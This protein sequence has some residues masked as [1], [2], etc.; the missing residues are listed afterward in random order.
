M[1]NPIWFKRHLIT[2]DG[3]NEQYIV[4][5]IKEKLFLKA[6]RYVQKGLY[7]NVSVKQNQ[8]I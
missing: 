6:K 2:Q 7:A 8:L 4:S 1:R 5:G 3:S